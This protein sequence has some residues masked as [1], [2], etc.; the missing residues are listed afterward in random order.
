MSLTPSAPLRFSS[1]SSLLPA[2][3][4]SSAYEIA[5][6]GFYRFHSS[7]SFKKGPVP[8]SKRRSIV[9][10][11]NSKQDPCLKNRYCLQCNSWQ[12]AWSRENNF[13]LI[14]KLWRKFKQHFFGTRNSKNKA[15]S[16]HFSTIECLLVPCTCTIPTNPLQCIPLQL[17]MYWC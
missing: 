16:F 15:P 14:I 13:P 4:S 17:W 2:T 6:R 12:D 8:G 9:E 1:L 5:L 11:W 3:L 7:P 10:K